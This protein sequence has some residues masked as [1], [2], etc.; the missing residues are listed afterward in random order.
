MDDNLI[1][2]ASESLFQILNIINIS[3][4]VFVDDSF[5]QEPNRETVVG[6]LSESVENLPAQ[7]Q[8]QFNEI[9]FDNSEVWVRQFYSLW[10]QLDP[11]RRR[12]VAL[13]ISSV[14]NKSI[15][16][17]K[18]DEGLSKL[19]KGKILF[20]SPPQ[21]VE[22]K[23]KI[24]PLISPE[25][26]YLLIFDQDLSLSSGFTSDGAKSGIGLIK[27]LQALNNQYITCCLL[28][29]KIP[30][31]ENEIEYWYQLAKD[32]TLNLRDFLPLAKLRLANKT[33]PYEFV[34][35]IKKALL[36]QYTEH[37]K[38]ITADVI[39]KSKDLAVS[40]LMLIDPYDFD[41]MVMVASKQEGNWEIESL[42]RLFD[43]FYKD[44]IAKIIF[45][46]EKLK[47]INGSV[48]LARR[49]S[50]IKLSAEVIYNFPQ[51]KPLRRKELYQNGELIRQTPLEVGDIFETNEKTRYILLAQPCDLMVREK[52]VRR[53]DE[54]F[55]PLAPIVF[56]AEKTVDIQNKDFWVNSVVL[57]NYSE[58]D[59]L[60]A[61]VDFTKNIQINIEVLDLSVLNLN[62]ECEINLQQEVMIP[63]HLT[64]GWQILLKKIVNKHKAFRLRLDEFNQHLSKVR[65][66]AVREMIWLSTMPKPWTR[67]FGASNKP[68]SNGMFNYGLRRIERYRRPGSE[69]LLDAYTQYLSRDADELDFSRLIPKANLKDQ[70]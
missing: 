63:E 14:L 16:D 28:S 7:L 13:Q 10:D 69:S 50:D 27:E 15:Q 37:L 55:V 40:E 32:N 36:N 68:Y 5:E 49:I 33:S 6:W 58:D 35:G 43:I 12:D 2:Q 56:K 59:S 30:S 42:I 34:D 51:V 4:V 8:E 52:G 67:D 48:N 24:L 25:N 3:Q 19:F 45:A 46:P 18:I 29:H 70:Q 54:F 26:R 9:D 39:N 62:G 53:I 22:E 60:V 1:T 11:K 20:L 65:H 47:E 41:L 57:S 64:T 21:W 31:K 23:E 17:Q 61:I 44:Q 66:E 38:Q